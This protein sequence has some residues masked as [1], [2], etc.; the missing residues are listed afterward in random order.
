[1]GIVPENEY[2]LGCECA[3]IVKRVA[4]GVTKFKV[5]D[6]VAANWMGCYAN[7]I[8]VPPARAHIIPSSMSFEDASTIP[9]VYL[10]ALYSLFHLGN[11]KEGQVGFNLIL[12][13]ENWANSFTVCSYP[14]SSW[15]CRNCSNPTCQIQE[16]R[17]KHS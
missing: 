3:G 9:V 16:G 12:I 5:G 1:M 14:L 6:R 17:R 11:L 10:T 4:P 15:W 8:Q 7:R 13:K 2:L